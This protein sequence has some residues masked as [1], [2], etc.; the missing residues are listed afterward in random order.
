MARIMVVERDTGFIRV[1]KQILERAG[2]EVVTSYPG[3]HAI[4]QLKAEKPDMVL[5]T[6][7]LPGVISGLR[8]VQ[9]IKDDP[10][11][12]HL[13][14]FMLLEKWKA[15]SIEVAVEAGADGYEQK[16]FNPLMLLAQVK[17]ILDH[18]Q[19]IP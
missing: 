11:T 8:L 5:T 18:F 10:S 15:E 12:K 9:Y 2:Y 6:D 16:A 3:E 7:T 19:T 1:L 14:V 13:P 17:S 4:H